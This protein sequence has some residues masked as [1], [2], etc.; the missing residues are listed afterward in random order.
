MYIRSDLSAMTER[1]KS[2]ALIV[3]ALFLLSLLV[4]LLISRIC[5]RR[6]SKPVTDLAET[7]RIVSREKNYAI[8]AASTGGQD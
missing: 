2:Y 5:Q 7:A 1:A 3:V 4:A 6:I 8:R